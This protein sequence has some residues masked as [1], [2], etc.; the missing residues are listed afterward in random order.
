MRAWPTSSVKKELRSL[1]SAQRAVDFRIVAVPSDLFTKWLKPVATPHQGVTL[2]AERNGA[3]TT[4]LGALKGLLFEHFVGEATIVQAGGYA[5]AAAIIA[6][7][8]P[9]NKK[10]RSGDLGEL[11][12]GI[13]SHPPAGRNSRPCARSVPSPSSA[14]G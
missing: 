6:D 11:L 9:S 14:G 1:P 2:Y 7:S 8:L 4:G 5:K 10:T 13:S 3:R 12:A